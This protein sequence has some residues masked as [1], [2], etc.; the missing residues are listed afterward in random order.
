MGRVV[1]PAGSMRRPLFVDPD[2]F[3]KASTQSPTPILI[4][5]AVTDTHGGRPRLPDEE[6]AR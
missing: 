3:S 6:A 5:M 4:V 2:L 1:L